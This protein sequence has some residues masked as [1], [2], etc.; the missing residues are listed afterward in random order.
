[1]GA[2][3]GFRHEENRANWKGAG[4]VVFQTLA[5]AFQLVAVVTVGV[6]F[7]LSILR[8]L[9]RCSAAVKLDQDPIWVVDEYA[10]DFALRVGE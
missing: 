2:L 3:I 6:G 10:A 9:L 4:L 1:M 5:P 7:Y 8:Q